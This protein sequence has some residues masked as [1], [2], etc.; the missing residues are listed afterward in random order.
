VSH[1]HFFERGIFAEGA[2]SCATV[3]GGSGLETT[4]V[5]ALAGDVATL[6]I[7]V[8]VGTVGSG[9]V[10]DDAIV[11]L[12][13]GGVAHVSCVPAIANMTDLRLDEVFVKGD[14]SRTALDFLARFECYRTAAR[15]PV[16]A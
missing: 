5:G 8:L 1:C 16:S 2:S 13:A 7:L 10:V 15:K 9:R 3:A 6:G 14:I 12:G 4:S 11:G